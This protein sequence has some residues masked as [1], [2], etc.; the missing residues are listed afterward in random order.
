MLVADVK[1]FSG[2]KSRYHSEITCEIPRILENAFARC[3]H[4]Y[5]GDAGFGGPSG[6]DGYCRVL[7]PGYLPYLVNPFLQALQD[8]LTEQ[9]NMLPRAYGNLRM[10]VSL[11]VG[12]VTDSGKELLGDGN[13]A[14]RIEAHRIL[15]SEPVRDILD[16]SSDVTRVAAIVSQ[17][18]YEDA[19]LA[20]YTAEEVEE[21]VEVTAKVKT[22]NSHAYLRVPKPSGRLLREGFL[23]GKPASAEVGEGE[24]SRTRSPEVAPRIEFHGRATQQTAIGSNYDGL[25]I[26]DSYSGGPDDDR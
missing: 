10:R 7:D 17:R 25:H 23:T 5:L 15:D 4:G 21:Y 14:T 16:R 2:T 1:D 11:S 22:F 6:G 19:V 24:V 26:G 18:V 8:E 3:G 9:N 13:G 20:G 12:P